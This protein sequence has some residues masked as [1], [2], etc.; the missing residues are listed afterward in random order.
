MLSTTESAWGTTPA[1]KKGRKINKEDQYI[2]WE[3]AS[4]H[5]EFASS[6]ILRNIKA[7]HGNLNITTRHVNR[8]RQEWGIS[9]K[10]GRP[11]G[12]RLLN[13]PAGEL[14]KLTPNLPFVGVC[15]L[16]AFVEQSGIIE[17]VVTAIQIKRDRYK[18]E[19]PEETF[20]LLFH[21]K[22]TVTM[23]FKALFYAAFFGCD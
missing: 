14:V 3:Y 11:C 16:D 15:I 10:K 8:L 7:E 22:Q 17:Q 23:R 6:V 18:E 4:R 1:F 9:R 2:L 20:P 13:A 21:K 19:H 5:P 12:R